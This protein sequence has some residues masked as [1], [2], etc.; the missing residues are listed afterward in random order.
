M[1]LVAK[2]SAQLVC[3][4]SQSF[5]M[6]VDISSRLTGSTINLVVNILIL[7]K[8]NLDP[9]QA[10]VS[11]SNNDSNRAERKGD[12]VSQIQSDSEYGLYR[13]IS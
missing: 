9:L 3:C 2:S 11:K 6:I 8:I 1:A 5:C 10:D 12:I 7:L 13:I 4:V